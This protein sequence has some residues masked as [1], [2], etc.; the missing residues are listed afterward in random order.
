MNFI[1]SGLKEFSFLHTPP[2]NR[3][4][5]KSFLKV[6]NL[7]LFK[8]A[9][10]R[11][12]SRGGQCFIVQNDISKM[13]FLKR[14]ISS[15]LP[16]ITID[17][18]HGKL[19]KNDISKV[20][21]D[22]D[23]G[24]LDVL[25]CTTIVEMGLDIPNAN[26]ILIID[27]QNFG[28]SQL[29]QLRGRV[30]RSVKQGYCYFLIPIPDLSKIAK[31]RL[32]SIIRLSDLGSGFFIAQEDLEIRGGGEMLGDKQSG[33]IN[34]VGIN[35]YLSMLKSALNKFK[36]NDE[37]ELIQTEINFYDSSYI[38]DDY[39]PSPLERLKIYKSLNKASSIYEIDQI[40]NELIDRC[41]A[42]TDEIKNLINDTKLAIIIQSSGIIKI[43]SN[44]YKTS[45]LLSAKIDKGVFDNILTLITKEPNIYSINNENKLIINLEEPS[46]SSRRNK[47]A[48][49]VNDIL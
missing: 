17:I 49:L 48:N 41:G 38:N 6:E 31:N 34:S 43:N 47:I 23:T 46:A 18:A 7:Q 25:I 14:S 13:E 20:M 26:T 22:F 3:I 45:F 9:I 33:H 29:H 16:E 21:R 40:K 11:E 28:L 32:D 4:S 37:K 39:L 24:I 10:S 35:L 8:E 15:I 44:A 19:N 42:L 27:A 1:F 5:I 36:N 30:G 12:V 2:T